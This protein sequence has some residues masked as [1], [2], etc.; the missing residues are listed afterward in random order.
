M[1]DPLRNLAD[2]LGTVLAGDQAEVRW[3]REPGGIYLDFSR[4]VDRFELALY[5]ARGVMS[6][7]DQEEICRLQGTFDEI[8]LPCWRALKSFY[9]E[10]NAEVSTVEMKALDRLI[11]AYRRPKSRH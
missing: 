11:D 1:D 7:A 10:E 6:R 3:D 8:I 9:G 4:D 2:G 5:F